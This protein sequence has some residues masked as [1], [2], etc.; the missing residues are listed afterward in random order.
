MR[1]IGQIEKYDIN[2]ITLKI[3]GNN[4]TIEDLSS[5]GDSKVVLEVS[6]LREH[7]SK[8]ANA[9]FWELVSRIAEKLNTDR[10]SIYLWMIRDAG[11]MVSMTVLEEALPNLEKVFRLIEQDSFYGDY[12]DV[13][14]YYGSSTY[15]TKEMARLIDYTRQE[16]IALGCDVY[17]DEEM[18]ALYDTTSNYKKTSN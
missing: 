6:K 7:R 13:R 11:V 8:S 15:D 1:C 10:E 3:N 2:H 4:K 14:C 12:V 5:L 18:R 16:A 17:T 9:Y